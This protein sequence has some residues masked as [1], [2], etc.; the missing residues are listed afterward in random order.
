MKKIFIIAI[1][2]F[3][4]NLNAQATPPTPTISVTGEGII[5]IIP[6]EA[7]IRVSV[8]N[9]GKEAAAVKG[10]NDE[11]IDQVLKYCKS[12]K[13]EAKDIQTERINLNKNYDYQ[14]K[15][16]NYVA[17]Q[18]LTIKLKDLEKYEKLMQGLLNSGINR[19]D[20]VVFKSS[21][22]ISLEAEARK[23]AMLNA[24]TKA[25]EYASAVDQKIG[26]AIYISE[27]NSTPQPPLPMYRTA[28]SLESTNSVANRETIAPGQ[29]EIISKI[30]VVFELK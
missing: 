17:N 16:Y 21:K 23:K 24:K 6:D 8:E 1:T 9:K 7:R 25:L 5:T 26:R 4:M 13:I 18:S 29:L 28:M 14:L 3:S 12:L 2:L 22:S 19:V 20:N 10:K 11:A 30:N 15:K 27:A